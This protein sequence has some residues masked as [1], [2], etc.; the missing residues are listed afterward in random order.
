[1]QVRELLQGARPAQQEEFYKAAT[2]MLLSA[3]PDSLQHALGLLEVSISTAPT[4]SKCR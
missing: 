4:S 3:G 2:Q 1:M